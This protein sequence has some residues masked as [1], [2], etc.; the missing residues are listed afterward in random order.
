MIKVNEL[1]LNELTQTECE[2]INAGTNIGDRIAYWLAYKWGQRC[3]TMYEDAV[4]Y[5]V[6]CD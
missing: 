6:Y 5:G 4:I 1:C 2:Q 3:R